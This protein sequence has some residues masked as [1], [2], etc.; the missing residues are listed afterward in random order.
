M[1]ITTCCRYHSRR[2][3]VSHVSLI[4]YHTSD[5][6]NALLGIKPEGLKLG[7]YL[8]KVHQ[9]IVAYWNFVGDEKVRYVCG[10]MSNTALTI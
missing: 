9:N 2:F 7:D 1:C 6:R 8:A 5:Y 10:I 4:I 3:S